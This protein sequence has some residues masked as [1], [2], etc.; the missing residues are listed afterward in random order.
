MVITLD[1][2]Y[3]NAIDR[4]I[5]EICKRD[6]LNILDWFSKGYEKKYLHEL[7]EVEPDPDDDEIRARERIDAKPEDADRLLEELRARYKNV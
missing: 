1:Q 3:R 4:K 2:E 5:V 6:N 7:Q